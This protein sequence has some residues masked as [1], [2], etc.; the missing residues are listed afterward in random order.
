MSIVYKQSKEYCLYIAIDKDLELRALDQFLRDIWLECCGH[1]SEFII[2]EE[3]YDSSP[4]EDFFLDG[5]S[6]HIKTGEVL[7]VG[8][9][10]KDNYDFES[11]TELV[12]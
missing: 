11:T 4:D 2:D 5:Q 10:F 8:D 1:L 3:R 7:E 6:M 12:I 9:K